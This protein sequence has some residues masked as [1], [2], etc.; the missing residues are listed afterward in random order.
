MLHPG[1]LELFHQKR[2]TSA[3]LAALTI[4]DPKVTFGADSQPLT[5]YQTEDDVEI[6]TAALLRGVLS[7]LT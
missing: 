6:P 5:S 2:S 1:A 3:A 7:I 4:S